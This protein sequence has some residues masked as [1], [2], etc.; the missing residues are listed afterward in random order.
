M[1]IIVISLLDDCKCHNAH[2]SLDTAAVP[3]TVKEFAVA[4][5]FDPLQSCAGKVRLPHCTDEETEMPAG[6]LFCSQPS[7][8]AEIQTQVSPNPSLWLS[9]YASASHRSRCNLSCFRNEGR[10]ASGTPRSQSFRAKK[11]PG[12]AEMQ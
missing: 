11:Y 7:N 4:T 6:E 10:M 2:H 12:K 8:R 9:L 3:D 1:V 5:S